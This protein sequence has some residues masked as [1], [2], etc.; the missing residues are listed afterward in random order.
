VF[1]YAGCYRALT[2]APD[3]NL[4]ANKISAQDFELFIP[5]TAL[6]AGSGTDVQAKFLAILK[7]GEEWKNLYSG[8]PVRFK[9]VK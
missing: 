8:E 3:K 5:Y 7:D 6:P 4:S 1:G 2:L 9:L